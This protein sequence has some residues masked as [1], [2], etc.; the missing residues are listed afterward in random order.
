MKL[1]KEFVLREIAGD[2]VIIPVGKTVIE[3]NGLITVNEVGV[4]IW[5]MLQ[6]EVTFDQIVQG[7]LNEYEVEES[8]AREDIREFLDQ[9]IDGGI[10]TEDKENGEE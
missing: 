6:N 7:I 4:S 3:F 9:L 8:V 10:L 1:E 2:Y 5:N